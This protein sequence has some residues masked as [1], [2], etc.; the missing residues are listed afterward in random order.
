MED[1]P[2]RTKTI[3][4]A[5]SDASTEPIQQAAFQGAFGAAMQSTQQNA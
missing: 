2:D 5:L 1:R 4:E 3:L